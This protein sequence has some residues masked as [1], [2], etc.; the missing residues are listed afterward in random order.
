VIETHLLYKHSNKATK[1]QKMC[2]SINKRRLQTINIVIPP[3]MESEINKGGE[4]DVSTRKINHEKST[5]SSTNVYNN[6]CL[7]SSKL[8][9][10]WKLHQ[11]L[12]DVE[13]NG[14]QSIVSWLEHGRSFKVHR[15]RSFVEKIIPSYFN[16]SKY[17]SFQRQLHLYGFTRMTR[18]PEAGSYSHP[19]FIRGLKTLCLSM[20]PTK[21][22]GTKL[23]QMQGLLPP[24]TVPSSGPNMIQTI[25]VQGG[26][27]KADPSEWLTQI[28]NLLMNGPALPTRMAK[29]AQQAKLSTINVSEAP[30][31]PHDGDLI[32]I[33]GGMPFHY[34]DVAPKLPEH[35]FRRGP[36][37]S[38]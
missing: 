35:G 11:M 4:D 28:E 20:T 36:V 33:F 18:G 12:E 24:G 15:P 27:V 2:N 17:K 23:R 21:I 9:F 8:P 26:S 16:Q 14:N 13:N 5:I 19:K 38:V 31:K 34:I 22:K 30:E 32:F 1:S 10:V 29:S 3:P 7:P 37:L 6:D 25:E